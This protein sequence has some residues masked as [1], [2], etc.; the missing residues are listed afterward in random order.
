MPKTGPP[1]LGG[2]GGQLAIP[3]NNLPRQQLSEEK[4]FLKIG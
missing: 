4:K 2:Q 1:E 3:P